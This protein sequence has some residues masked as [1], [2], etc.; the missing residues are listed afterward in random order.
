MVTCLLAYLIATIIP[1]Q[2]SW[3]I[4][5]QYLSQNKIPILICLYFKQA[6]HRIIFVAQKL[7]HSLWEMVQSIIIIMLV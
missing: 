4:N 6:T 3:P 1:V 5:I 2:R 7:V